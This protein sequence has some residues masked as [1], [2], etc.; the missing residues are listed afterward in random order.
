M[1][2][3]RSVATVSGHVSG[4]DVGILPARG[5]KSRALYDLLVAHKGQSIC[6]PRE[7]RPSMI[8]LQD[9]YGLDI[10]RDHGA[11]GSFVLK[12]EWRGNEYHDHVAGSVINHIADAA[13]ARR[14]R[15]TLAMGRRESPGAAM[16]SGSNV[17]GG[18]GPSWPQT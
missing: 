7:L 14:D 5:T 17:H 6:I 9:F 11:P 8:A 15:R 18:L 2:R 3:I 1:A 10:S 4:A 16:R 13:K 12:G